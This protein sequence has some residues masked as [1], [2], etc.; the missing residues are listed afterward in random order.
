MKFLAAVLMLVAVL[1]PAQTARADDIVI[2]IVFPVAGENYY[3]DTF[4]APRA[5][6]LTHEGTDI[7]SAKM[8]PVVA[9][10]SGTV[11]WVS[12]TCCGMELIHDD[13]YRSRYIHLNNDTPGTDDGLGWGFAPGIVS[14]VHVEA[15]QLIGW[16]G[17]SGNAEFTAPHLH[18]ELRDSAGVAFNSYPS[19]L[20]ATPP[21]LSETSWSTAAVVSGTL[22]MFDPSVSLAVHSDIA[23]P[24]V[25]DFDGDNSAEV[26]VGGQPG[27][28]VDVAEMDGTTTSWADVFIGLPIQTLVGDFDDDGDDD[29]GAM[30]SSG[31]WTGY[32]SS[33]SEFA[34][35]EW[36]QHKGK[37]WEH[38]L[39]GN[40]DDDGAEEIVAFHPPSST[41]WIS[42][43]T[44]TGW[45][46]AVYAKY[47]TTG[48]WQVHVAA[49]NDGDGRDEILSFHP[50]NGTWWSTGVGETSKLVINLNTN[51][52]WS[53][54]ASVDVDGDGVDELVQYHS[55][56]GTWWKID[57]SSSPAKVKLWTTFKT[58]SGWGHPTPLEAEDAL[59][60][61]HQGTGNVYAIIGDAGVLDYLGK[62]LP[63]ELEGFWVGGLGDT[64]ALVALQRG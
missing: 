63:G 56:N 44:T 39:V 30:S 31:Y 27:K 4:G 6:G 23:F 50:S 54:H 59:A 25:G 53:N 28:G 26:A 11:G 64:S 14:G 10:A 42:N 48:G 37:P 35:E 21:D 13:G 47:L 60:V 38:F 8:T 52:G 43:L 34:I 19:L 5:G 45:K 1:L 32:R 33:G 17:D 18:F 36:G 3:T 22:D 40:F 2:P 9:A 12:T 58:K 57:P 24:F 55:S 46:H 20:V 61:R 16:V 62:M 49:D 51:S 15:G 29:I 7:M 41:W